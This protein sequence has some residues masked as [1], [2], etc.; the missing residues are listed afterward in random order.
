MPTDDRISRLLDALSGK[1]SQEK[2]E[3]FTSEFNS[4]HPEL[5]NVQHGRDSS[6]NPPRDR[7][8]L[9]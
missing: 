2:L 5:G 4:L 6:E 1:L 9:I 8:N 7:H 3:S